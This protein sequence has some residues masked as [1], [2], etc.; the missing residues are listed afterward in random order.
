MMRG[1]DR[2]V[3]FGDGEWVWDEKEETK[4]CVLESVGDC[5][6][7]S[8]VCAKRVCVAL[9]EKQHGPGKVSLE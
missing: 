8:G 7:Q 1:G 3:L 4:K 2:I 6:Y 9:N 5:V